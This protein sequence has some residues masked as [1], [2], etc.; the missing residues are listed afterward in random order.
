LFGSRSTHA[1]SAKAAAGVQKEIA[2]KAHL[3]LK[4][5]FATSLI[6][7]MV[8]ATLSTLSAWAQVKSTKHASPESGNAKINATTSNP[9]VF[10]PAVTY[11]SGGQNATSV[12]VADVNGDGIPDVLVTNGCGTN[13]V[14]GSVGVLLG[15]GDGTFQTAVTYGS[16][17]QDATSVA[18]GDLNGDGR[19]DLAVVNGGSTKVGVLLG[20]GDG[21]F[22]PVRTYPSGGFDSF[23][24]A[25][26]DVNGDG[27]LDLLIANCATSS[28]SN[29]GV[30][31]G[32]VGVLLGKG[33]GTFQAAVTYDSGGQGATSVA[34][35]DLN[36]DGNPDLVVSLYYGC[37]I[38]S[39]CAGAV[40][41][42]LGN[43]DGTFQ[44]VQIYNSGGSV[45][46]SVAVED[47][48]GNG[49]PDLVVGNYGI[50]LGTLPGGL[51]VLLDAGDHTF[52]PAAIYNSG[53]AA[54]LS[55]A[56]ADVNGDGKPDVL[57]ANQCPF[58][59]CFHQAVVSVL[60]GNGDGTVQKAVTFNSGGYLADSVAVGDLNGDGRP[61]VV[62][63]N[64]CNGGVSCDPEDAP[65]GPGL[66]G[67]LLNNTPFC[68]T[69]PVITLSI[70]P[71]SLR[72]PNG[73]LAPVTVSGAVSETAGCTVNAK[74]TAYAV[75]DEY[76]LIQPT[77]GII[78]GAGGTYSFTVPLQA[79]RLGK[80]LDGR[81][82]TITVRA[83]DNAGN[84]GSAS[85]V[86][87]VPH[88]QRH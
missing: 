55:V 66:V 16:G 24:V 43:G 85:V 18:V 68:T 2:M 22:Q 58:N 78:L 19:P 74:T 7:T 30:E 52:Q 62:V 48:N 86:V 50:N 15:D 64:L 77:G 21:T 87:T 25:I 1:V 39:G 38:I 10:L 81:Q 57:A 29:C 12:A 20:N 42:L 11:A 59:D 84:A 46:S 51:G 6:T 36:V 44:P 35:G 71:R 28:A 4:E 63:A 49:R 80:D 32:V 67:V 33:D 27:K 82:Y 70:S 45:A 34:V 75:T 37:P 9:P 17:G 54:A 3:Q 69:P 40:G 13:C 8:L 47:L 61:D 53:G 31:N 76:G 88:D 14:H 79:S 73:R 83:T 60:L 65:T 56:V 26:A 72:P 23:S 5:L 41:V